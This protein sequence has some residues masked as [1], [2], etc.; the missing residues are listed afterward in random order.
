MRLKTFSAPSMSDAMRLVKNHFGDE[1]IIIS[2]QKDDDGLGVRITAAIEPKEEDTHVIDTQDIRKATTRTDIIGKA[3]AHHGT[4]KLVAD[5]LVEIAQEFE[6]DDSKIALAGAVDRL[7]SFTPLPDGQNPGVWMLVGLP[8]SGKTVTSAKLATQAVMAKH[9]V[10]IITTDTVRAGGV[11]QLQA[12]TKILKIDLLKAAD[13]TS[14]QDAL[15]ACNPLGLTIIDCAGSTPL[16]QAGFSRQI[17]LIKAIKSK[18]ILVL[19]DGTDPNEAAELA[20]SYSDVGAHDIILTR[21]DTSRR[22][23]SLLSAASS[24]KLNICGAGIGPNVAD[25]LKAL[26]PVSLAHLLLSKSNKITSKLINT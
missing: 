26:N 16:K 8:G 24:G 1:A 5:K 22:H 19:A 9:P 11:Q 10:N 21:V 4:P 2:S 20:Q 23:G 14:L 25:G 13:P 15:A 18:V 6:I 17:D 7:F 12:F 3:L